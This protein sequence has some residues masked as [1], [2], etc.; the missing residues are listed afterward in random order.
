[1][2]EMSRKNVEDR[3]LTLP[4][5]LHSEFTFSESFLNM[6]PIDMVMKA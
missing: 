2:T 4:R 5:R 1:M 6:F 3:E